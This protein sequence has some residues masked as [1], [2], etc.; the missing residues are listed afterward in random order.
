MLSWAKVAQ[1]CLQFLHSLGELMTFSQ[2]P[3]L[4]LYEPVRRISG[5]INSP[6]LNGLC[7]DRVALS[8]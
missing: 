3:V 7:Q 8:V 4:N 6:S 5:F 1:G 2:L